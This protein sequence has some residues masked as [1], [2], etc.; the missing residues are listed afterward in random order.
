[1]R[2]LEE[3]FPRAKQAA[4]LPQTSIRIRDLVIFEQRFLLFPAAHCT[5][6]LTQA[7]MAVREMWPVEV[8]GSRKPDVLVLGIVGVA[9]VGVIVGVVI[10]ALVCRW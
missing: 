7:A 10:G 8:L 2:I 9:I 5:Q 1:M 6:N 3:D 4:I